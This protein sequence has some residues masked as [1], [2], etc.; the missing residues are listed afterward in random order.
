MVEWELSFFFSP[1]WELQDSGPITGVQ[2]HR[3]KQTVNTALIAPRAAHSTATQ[4][5][6]LAS[7]TGLL[8][9]MPGLPF[10]SSVVFTSRQGLRNIVPWLHKHSPPQQKCFHSLCC[11]YIL[12]FTIT[13]FTSQSLPIPQALP[14]LHFLEASFILNA[15]LN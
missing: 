11:D 3:S 15:T 14:S 2:K 12:A 13:D 7:L 5:C 1:E 8:S 6:H 9:A 10:Y 4:R